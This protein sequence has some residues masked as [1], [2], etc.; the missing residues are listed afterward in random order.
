MQNTTATLEDSWQILTKIN[1]LLLYDPIQCSL[2]P[3]KILESL[4][5]YENL[6][7]DVYSIFIH[8]CQNM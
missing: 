7:I 1:I 2:L 5:P 8:N 4:C 6:H 3:P